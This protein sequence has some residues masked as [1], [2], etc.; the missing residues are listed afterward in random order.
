MD[1]LTPKMLTARMEL[2]HGAE[3]VEVAV[4][5][6]CFSLSKKILVTKFQVVK[7]FLRVLSTSTFMVTFHCEHR[8]LGVCKLLFL[9]LLFWRHFVKNISTY[10]TY[11][12]ISF[13]CN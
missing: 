4:T 3:P 9:L 6:Y 1:D 12:N 2:L 11:I 10:C 13:Y 7:A 8:S 5:N